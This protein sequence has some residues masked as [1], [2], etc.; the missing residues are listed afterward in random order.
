MTGQINQLPAGEIH[1]NHQVAQVFRAS[2]DF[3]SGISII[4]ATYARANDCV[5][6]AELLDLA[7]PSALE[8]VVVGVVHTHTF[9]S[10][11]VRDNSSH[12]MYFP[13]IA[14]STGNY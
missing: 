12:E 13:E 6:I 2:E 14:R 5:L 10:T 3:L 11:E 8:F 9:S 1:G 7:H 4:L